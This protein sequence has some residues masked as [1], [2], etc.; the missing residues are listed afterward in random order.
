[1]LAMQHADQLGYKLLCCHAPQRMIGDIAPGG[2]A[3]LP[4]QAVAA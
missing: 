4:H 2:I 3:C 1:M